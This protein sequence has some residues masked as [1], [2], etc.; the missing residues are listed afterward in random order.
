MQ[1]VQQLQEPALRY[2]LEVARCGSL[3]QASARLHV[4]SSALSRQIAHLEDVLGTPLFERHARGMVLNA[5]GEIL[6]AHARRMQL[7]AERSV[8]EIRS[9]QG[10]RSGRVRIAATAAFAHDVVPRLIVEF[11][12]RHEG[13]VFD[14][15]TVAHDAVAHAVRHGDADIGLSLSR[16]PA[17]DLNVELR[18]PAPVC[19]LLPPQHPLAEA[20]TLTLRRL[21]AQPIAL[22]P[23][24]TLV[25]DMVDVALSRQ[26][27]VLTA[28]LT[29]N[30]Q[31][32][33][34]A[35]VV[36]GG[37]IGLSGAMSARHLEKAGLLVVRPLGDRGLD[38]R[39]L[40]VQ[41][42]AGR[43][44]PHAVAA[45]VEHLRAGLGAVT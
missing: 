45:F 6:A 36:N 9:L 10:L 30:D 14:L 4:A 15:R 3:A 26:Q 22:P 35:F 41:T 25:R 27:L 2:F 31:A 28:A 5:A 13:I 12:H 16:A 19:A 23:T 43:T 20:R 1:P 29:T 24:G 33:V 39:D 21:A 42:L 44:L 8:G 32:A 40:E 38:Q 11:R 34:H 18:Q 37:G 7:D 17:A